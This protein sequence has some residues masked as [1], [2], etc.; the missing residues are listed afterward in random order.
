MRSRTGKC[1]LLDAL[2]ELPHISVALYAQ[3][4]VAGF[5]L[6][7]FRVERA[8]ENN[9]FRILGDVHEPARSDGQPAEFGYVDVSLLVD[10]AEPQKRDVET[11]AGVKIELRR[12][13]DHAAGIS[14]VAEQRSGQQRAAVGAMLN[15]LE[16]PARASVGCNDCSDF[17]RNPES[18]VDDGSIAEFLLGSSGHDAS[19]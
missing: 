12:T 5:N 3:A 19:N 7:S 2:D 18:V 1:D 16:I 8:A 14:R 6:R 11:A 13:V 4:S 9:F 10:F 15:G 17:I